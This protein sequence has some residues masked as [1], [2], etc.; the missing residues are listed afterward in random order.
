[1]VAAGASREVR[2]RAGPLPATAVPGPRFRA[3]V[4]GPRF[5]GRGSG[6]RFR[7]R[8]DGRG[9][10]PRFRLS[11][12]P[13]PA[14]PAAVPGSS[15][16]RSRLFRLPFRQ[17]SM[18]SPRKLV[19]PARDRDQDGQAFMRT[20]RGRARR[21]RVQAVRGARTH[22]SLPLRHDTTR[23]RVRGG[24]EGTNVALRRPAPA[25]KSH[26]ST[27]GIVSGEIAP[28]AA[29]DPP[30]ECKGAHAPWACPSQAFLVRACEPSGPLQCVIEPGQGPEDPRG[31]CAAIPGVRF[32]RRA[33]RHDPPLPAVA[34]AA[35]PAV[36]D[37]AAIE[38][39]VA[40][41]ARGPSPTAAPT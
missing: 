6:A 19:P 41:A 35:G 31:G 20:R 37:R 12:L 4:P 18:R 32:S 5:R 29:T 22:R 38:A 40:A 16:C 2:R 24:Q 36:A 30:G 26:R 3:A 8:G 25:A 7:G 28:M 21:R 1:M 9:S 14:L 23:A 15:G 11:R 13:F 39:A 33:A 27:T 17:C 10:G 34:V